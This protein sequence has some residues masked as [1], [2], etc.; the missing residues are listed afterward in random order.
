VVSIRGPLGYE[1]NTLTTAPLRS[2]LAGSRENKKKGALAEEKAARRS[3][4]RL[5]ILFLIRRAL[6]GHTKSASN[7][8]GWLPGL[9]FLGCGSTVQAW[10]FQ[11]EVVFLKVA[12]LFTPG[13]VVRTYFFQERRLGLMAFRKAARCNYLRKGNSEEL[14]PGRW[15]GPVALRTVAWQ[16]DLLE[17]GY[18]RKGGS[19]ELLPGRWFRPI[20]FR[21]VVWQNYLPEGDAHQLH[22]GRWFVPITLRKVARRNYLRKGGSD[23]LLSGRWFGRI[24]FRKVVRAN[25]SPEGGS[26]IRTVWMGHV[27]I[28]SFI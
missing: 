13:K 23:Q 7:A 19:E 28:P 4:G 6:W 20:T 17:G 15:L 12:R 3:V 10:G 1:P 27:I 9:G 11:S 25:Y 5:G 21:K 14:L 22:S 18:L 16:N 26:A 2:Y 24:T 8:L